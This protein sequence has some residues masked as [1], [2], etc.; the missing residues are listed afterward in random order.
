MARLGKVKLVEVKGEIK[1]RNQWRVSTP[2]YHCL[3]SQV[4]CQSGLD[5]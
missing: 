4:P 3:D 1:S 5:N 2:P